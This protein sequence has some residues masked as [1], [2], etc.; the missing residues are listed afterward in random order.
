MRSWILLWVLLWNVA[1]FVLM[2]LDK[3]RAK[4]N[5]WRI[6]EKVLFLSAAAGGS[7]GALLGMRF[8]QHKTRHWSFR[9]GMPMLFALQLVGLL[10]WTFREFLF[11]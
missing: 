4:G 7:V 6:P 3:G 1:A 9:I 2:G 5:Q 8:F 10:L 11:R